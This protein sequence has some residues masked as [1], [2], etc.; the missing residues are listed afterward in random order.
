M[1]KIIAAV[2]VAVL[3]I[4]GIKLIK[5]RKTQ[6]ANIAPAKV[7]PVV[8]DTLDLV[9]KPVILTLPAMGIVATELSATLSTKISSRVKKVYKKEGDSVKKGDLLATLDA[10]DLM[11]KKK[12]LILKKQSLGFEINAGLEN[13]KALEASFAS[14]RE[15]HLRTE[16]LLN[17]K[18][19]SMEQYRGE[20]A[21]LAKI[22]AQ[23]SAARNSIS[24]LKKNQEALSQNIKEVESL[25]TYASITS[26]ISGTLS[27]RMVMVGDMTG[28]GK[29]LFQISAGSGFYINMFLPDSVKPH[30][31][32]FHGESLALVPKN[33]ATATGLVQ[34][35]AALSDSTGFVEGQYVNVQ[36]VVYQ[37]ETSLLPM[38]GIL[39]V[40]GKS[41][42][43]VMEG[44]KAEKI[45]VNIIARGSEG[46]V[47]DVDLSGK[48]V[49]TAKPDILLRVSTGVPIL[50]SENQK[51][52]A[53]G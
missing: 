47:V 45:S 44:S 34:Y 7:L 3:V 15:T 49:I 35:L 16:E 17:V 37:G 1:K 50:T 52:T 26:P 2:L 31:I 24:V 38:D 39:N 27:K 9:K 28:P 43:Y 30:S 36:V 4:A 51:D 13:I 32:I 23:Q 48:T 53:K 40:G 42:V 10:S 12:G 20:E 29:T 25:L 22:K 21:N 19:A 46:L 11:A 33:Q 14:A 41:F 18:G 8:V 6:L 5:I